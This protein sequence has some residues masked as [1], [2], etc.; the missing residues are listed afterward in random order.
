VRRSG[1]NVTMSRFLPV[2]AV[3][4]ATVLLGGACGN[5][6]TG[7]A[8]PTATATSRPTASPT[9]SPTVSA[10]TKAVCAAVRTA[11]ETE[12]KALGGEVGRMI[13]NRTAS[14]KDEAEKAK[15]RAKEIIRGLAGKLR[16]Q[17]AAAEDPA[18]KKALTESADSVAALA[19][20]S[21]IDG[22]KSLDEVG[23]QLVRISDALKPVN[24]ICT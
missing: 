11:F 2:A 4:V 9:A 22:F 15:Q 21:Y 14:S 10:N 1:I 19:D 7:S 6:G 17:A 5:I 13:G 18:L 12:V 16:E 23:A 20:D 24:E 3:A 8:T